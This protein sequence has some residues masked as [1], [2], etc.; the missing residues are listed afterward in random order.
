M[1][2]LLSY[3]I[4]SSRCFCSC[5]RLPRGIYCMVEHN[6]KLEKIIIIRKMVKHVRYRNMRCFYMD[7][8]V[9]FRLSL[10]TRFLSK[11]TSKEQHRREIIPSICIIVQLMIQCSEEFTIWHSSNSI[12]IFKF[13]NFKFK[14]KFKFSNFLLNLNLNANPSIY[15]S[16]YENTDEFTIHRNSSE[17][18][19]MIQIEIKYRSSIL[20]S[21]IGLKY[22]VNYMEKIVDKGNP[23]YHFAS[24]ENLGVKHFPRKILK[25]RV[26][27]S[28][29]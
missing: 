1:F 9:V 4:C 3:V 16:N 2:S 11:M 26:R 15:Y 23:L 24:Y 12:Q 29:F 28:P 22:R 8:F 21:R 13:S 10:S 19:F 25:K 14:F 18:T 5:C 27:R 17:C 7:G 20:V 6:L